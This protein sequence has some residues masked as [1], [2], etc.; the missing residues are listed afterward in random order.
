MRLTAA[1][2]RHPAELPALIA[3]LGLAIT[4]LLAV[5]VLAVA[6]IV[7]PPL[8]AWPLRVIG[9]LLLVLLDVGLVLGLVRLP[10]HI[11]AVRASARPV[12]PTNYRRIHEAAELAAQRL[13]LPATPPVFLLIEARAAGFT[14]AW[15]RSEIYLTE[16]LADALG[17]LELRAALAHEMGR[18]RDRRM[19]LVTGVAEPLRARLV[20]PLLRG[21]F[22]LAWLALRP[23]D[24]A[25]QLSADR[26]A[27]IVVGGAEPVAAWLNVAI[28]G[29]PEGLEAEL[30]HYLTFGAD[31]FDRAYAE[32]QL[33]AEYPRIAGRVIELARFVRSERFARCLALIGDLRLEVQPRVT[34]PALPGVLP[35]AIIGMLAGLWLT[36]VTIALTLALGAPEP[37]VAP[38][39]AAPPPTATFDPHAPQTLP[40]PTA[41]APAAQAP[42]AQPAAPTPG[43]PED[44]EGLLEVARI[45]KNHGDLGNARRTLEDIL[46]RNPMMVEAHYMLAWVH[47]QAGDKDLAADEFRAVLNL[48][49]PG[50][51]HYREAVEA[52]ERLGY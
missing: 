49:D 33:R 29:A 11:A 8:G 45:H 46:L 52:L 4:L 28:E 19:Q 34:D 24:R 7:A 23:W 17:D 3:G 43:S 21:C 50:S 26:A 13:H 30:R 15:P 16:G 37:V 6:L 36:P 18:L 47:V 48:A 2:Y 25:A 35:F 5:H 20:H 9:A 38:S 41:Q 1:D 14:L 32:A 12:G 42:A 27:A 44:L 22:A 10:R 31:R 40:P 39:R 51:E